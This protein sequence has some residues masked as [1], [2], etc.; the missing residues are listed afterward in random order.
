MKNKYE[1]NLLKLASKLDEVSTDKAKSLE[2]AERILNGDENAVNV[3]INGNELFIK[4]HAD[5]KK[6]GT[7][8][9]VSFIQTYYL[10]EKVEENK[11]KKERKG[12][13]L[14]ITLPFDD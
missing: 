8:K 2:L 13:K 10:D 5:K 4:G 7:E 3:E 6:L 11:M 9:M 12:E 14:I 1:A